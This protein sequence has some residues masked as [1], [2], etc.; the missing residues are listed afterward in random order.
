MAC[1]GQI[2]FGITLTV[3]FM[4]AIVKGRPQLYDSN[5][6]EIEQLQSG[7][8]YNPFLIYSYLNRLPENQYEKL[9]LFLDAQQDLKEDTVSGG[10][11]VELHLREPMIKRQ[12]VRYR[13]CYFNPISCFRK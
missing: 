13:Q 2:F 10:R 1:S 3:I 11:A 7:Q 12:A 5:V 4:T 9:K 8:T 6:N